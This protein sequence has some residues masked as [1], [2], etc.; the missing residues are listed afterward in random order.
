MTR[1]ILDRNT[2]TRIQGGIDIRWAIVKGLTNTVRLSG[3][4]YHI[5]RDLY[6]PRIL[7]RLGNN[8]G[9]AELG[10]Y[11]KT[12]ALVEDFLEYKHA[13][14]GDLSMEAI[15][16]VSYQRDRY[17]QTDLAASGF[18]SDDLKNYN[19]SSG[20][21]I[22]KPLTDITENT[23]LSAFARVRFNMS[24]KYLF[25][26]SIRR[27]GASVFAADN[28]YGVF[29]SV[30]AAWRVTGEKFMEKF[31]WVSNLKLRASWGQAG[32]PAIKPYQSLLLGKTVNTGQGAG[33]G[34]AVGI[35]PTFANPALKW[36][37]T[38]QT[39]I[40]LDLGLLRDRFRITFDYYIKKLPTCWPWYSYRHQAVLVRASVQ[41]RGRS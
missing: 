30:S 21:A 38:A 32:N 40:G 41:A 18:G 5:R 22:S 35:A 24:D 28:K 17:D 26:A 20:N 9:S 12:S 3:D 13:F 2:T 8:I 7:P 25:A 6:Y 29:P 14:T 36:E 39:N 19:F 37:T 15:G 10:Q 27:D 23:I 31:T 1:E 4:F 11:D 33:A 16:G 34:L